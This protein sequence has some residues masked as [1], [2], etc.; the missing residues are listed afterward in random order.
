MI[1]VHKATSGDVPA[2]CGG[3]GW[4]HEKL[5]IVSLGDKYRPVVIR[6]CAECL[7]ELKDILK[8]FPQKG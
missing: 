6:L 4:S 7:K 2:F 8:D 5:T 1:K 3:C